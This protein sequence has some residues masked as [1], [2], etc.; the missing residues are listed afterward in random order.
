MG[1]GDAH[2]GNYSRCS[3]PQLA[4]NWPSSNLT[5]PSEAFPSVYASKEDVVVTKVQCKNLM[6][7]S[8]QH[9]PEFDPNPDRVICDLAADAEFVVVD[10]AAAGKDDDLDAAGFV[11][12]APY[13]SKCRRCGADSG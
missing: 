11:L 1:S 13:Q 2:D 9:P 5:R 6:F 4:L 10:F 3:F 12:V 8:S 7:D